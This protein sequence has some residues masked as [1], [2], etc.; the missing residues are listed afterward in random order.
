MAEILPENGL[1]SSLAADLTAV[2]TTLKIVTADAIKWPTGGEYRAIICQDPTNGPY[3]LVRVTGGQGTDTLTITRAVESYNGDQTARAWVTGASI[4]AVITKGGLQL[5]TGNVS[6]PLNQNLTFTPDVT[7]DIGLV[8]ANRPRNMYL[9][10]FLAETEISTPTPPPAGSV[11]IYPKADHHV[12]SLDST[13]AETDLT[14]PGMTQAQGD[15]RYPLKTDVDPYPQYQTKAE[16]DALYVTPAQVASTYLPLVGGTLTGGLTLAADPTTNLQAATKQYADTKLTQAQ[17]DARYPQKTDADPYTQYLTQARADTRYALIGSGLSLPLTQNLTFSPDATYDVGASGGS[18]PRNIFA[19]GFAQATNMFVGYGSP[20]TLTNTVGAIFDTGIA[21]DSGEN[22]TFVTNGTTRWR[23]TSTGMLWATADNSYDIGASGATRPRTIYAATSFVGPGAVPTG[24]TVGQ[25]LSKVDA[26]NYNLQWT[27]P[28]TGVTWPLRAPDGTQTAPSYSFSASTGAGMWY[29]SDASQLH[30]VA[31]S[32][33][34]VEANYVLLSGSTTVRLNG[35]WEVPANATFRPVNDNSYDIGAVSANRPRTIYVG[36]KVVA[37]RVEAITST[38]D[39]LQL[40]APGGD[41]VLMPAGT[42]RWRVE[43]NNGNLWATT[44]NTTDI[45]AT[46]ANRPRTVYVGTSVIVPQINNPSANIL[47]GQNP[48]GWRFL[49][50]GHLVPLSDSSQDLGASPTKVNNVYAV[51]VRASGSFIGSGAV[52]TGGTTGQVLS[53]SSATDY[54]LSWITPFSQT[55]ADGLY[56]KLTGG[57]VSFLNTT[58]SITGSGSVPTGG[59][60]G[61]VLTKSGAGDYALSWTT[62]SSGGLSLPLGQNLTFSP[63]NTYDIGATSTTLRPRDLFLARNQVV[64]GTGQFTGNVGIGIAPVTYS[65]IYFQPTMSGANQFALYAPLTFSTTGTG[66]NFVFYTLPTFAASTRTV[67]SGASFYAD[68]PTLGSG[69][70]VTGMFG[71]YAANQGKSGVTNA[72]G[73]YIAAQSGAT[74]L[75]FGLYNA[76]STALMS[77]VAIGYGGATFSGAALLIQPTA[78]MLTGT[79]QWELYI[80]GTL[81]SA[82]TSAG[83]AIMAQVNTQAAS[84]TMANATTIYAQSPGLGAGSAITTMNGVYVV[85]QG[86]AGRTTAYGIYLEQTSGS[87]N[88]YGIRTNG[89]VNVFGGRTNFGGTDQG[90][91]HYFILF[92]TTPAPTTGFGGMPYGDQ[93]GLRIEYWGNSAATGSVTGL[94]SAVLGGNTSK[95]SFANGIQ[96]GNPG[97]QGSGIGTSTGL[98]IDNVVSGKDN[99]YEIW[100]G[101][102]SGATGDNKSIVFG[103]SGEYIRNPKNST[104]NLSIESS[105]GY[106]MISSISGTHMGGN[107]YWDGTNWQRYSTGS[108]AAAWIASA[109]TV[110]MYAVGAGANPISWVNVISIDTSGNIT[111]NSVTG[112]TLTSSGVLNVAS[113]SQLHYVV[114]EGIDIGAGPIYFAHSGAIRLYYDGSDATYGTSLHTPQHLHVDGTIGGGNFRSEA[115]FDAGGNN[116]YFGH[117][118]GIYV[119]WTNG[120]VA[121]SHGL[122]ISNSSNPASIDTA[123]ARGYGAPIIN[124]GQGDLILGGAASNIYLHPNLTVGISQTYP[125]I[126]FF[127]F[128]GMYCNGVTTNSARRDKSNIETID[129]AL[130]IVMSPELVGTHFTHNPPLQV[131]RD[132][133]K[134]G[135]IADD[136]QEKAPDVVSVDNEGQVIGMDYQQVTAILFQ[137]FKEYVDRTDARIAELEGKAA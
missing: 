81:S 113:T 8:A 103:S 95:T 40:A 84:F 112:A 18:R 97:D 26:T 4:A 116:Y 70:T 34:S 51:T 3:E 127:G 41:V 96:I 10:G 87:T 33:F 77:P 9:A 15:L 11:Y 67:A 137:A 134:F 64:G 126:T 85:N 2:A 110:S 131:E 80:N 63:D 105:D 27:T 118:A 14:T 31:P 19:S 92:A 55:T 78:G 111:C 74:T 136:W 75:N 53:K 65:G 29:E 17:A 90:D 107:A 54:A 62:P 102:P 89:P 71:V 94:F 101:A 22:L 28:A 6:L 56:L 115:N 21:G 61:Q 124:S 83:Y 130:Q 129:N 120:R 44:D 5:A 121:V 88:N 25:V 38:F 45:G 57:T 108:G 23:I 52:P 119:T 47:I 98:R 48:T 50:T 59:S 93:T 128:T 133:K 104:A 39:D 35:A 79:S 132:V 73:V 12:Y 24:G 122:T 91:Q 123:V 7:Y 49:S 60:T 43:N 37:S 68:S 99:N 125:T 58:G 20:M 16:N 76:G 30:I 100:L 72:Y 117:N 13:G 135:F 114:C 42:S 32:I 1:N 69:V 86:G 82:A 46:A 66:N 109:G 106:V 36:T